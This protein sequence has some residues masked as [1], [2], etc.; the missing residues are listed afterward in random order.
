MDSVSDI[1]IT[2]QA[3]INASNYDGPFLLMVESDSQGTLFF[4][5]FRTYERA[6]KMA[7]RVER[8]AGECW[9]IEA[10][11]PGSYAPEWSRI[12]AENEQ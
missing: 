11:Q 3:A 4:G 7:A 10:L 2:H 9:S 12:I 6:A 5:P 8:I 1:Y